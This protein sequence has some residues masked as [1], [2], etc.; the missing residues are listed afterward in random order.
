MSSLQPYNQPFS[1][2]SSS[3]FGFSASDLSIIQ[4]GQWLP[5]LSHFV[6]INSP[7][8]IDANLDQ[9]RDEGE[10]LDLLLITALNPH[11]PSLPGLGEFIQS[12]D[13]TI[14]AA[15]LRG[16][17]SIGEILRE[18]SL[19]LDPNYRH[20]LEHLRWLLTQNLDLTDD[21]NPS[22]QLFKRLCQEA[23][24]GSSDLTRWAAAYALQALDYPA[25]LRKWLLHKPP[26]EIE[27]E[28]LH[29]QKDQIS[30]LSESSNPSEKR[31]C[32][33]FWVYGPTEK[34]FSEYHGM[35]HQE[36]VHEVLSKLGMRGIR[37]A[38][39][40]G[41]STTVIEVIKLARKIFNQTSP[42][43]H[44]ARYQDR[45]TRQN[46]ANRLLPLLNTDNIQLRNLVAE[47]LNDA[48]NNYAVSNQLLNPDDRAKVA[49][50]DT[51]SSSRWD[52]VV[53]LGEITIPVLR[54]A[55]EGRLKFI[56]DEAQN[57]GFQIEAL[58]AIDRIIKDA[59]LKVKTLI[60]YL[61]HDSD[62]IRLEAFNFLHP[63]KSHLNSEYSQIIVA[64]NFQ[65][66][67][68][69]KL[70][71]LSAFQQ[72]LSFGLP[73][74]KLKME[75]FLL[76]AE[77]QKKALHQTF[78]K[79]LSACDNQTN[80]KD[81]LIKQ[82]EMFLEEISRYLSLLNRQQEDYNDNLKLQEHNRKLEAELQK[83]K[84]EIQEMEETIHRFQQKINQN[85]DEDKFLLS[86]SSEGELCQ[87]L[88]F[89]FLL[90]GI[91][92]ILIMQSGVFSLI[93]IAILVWAILDWSAKE[94][95]QEKR[96]QLK[97]Q[98]ANLN[99]QVNSLNERKYRIQQELSA[100][101]RQIK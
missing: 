53:S 2:Q 63:L 89:A 99:I 72:D 27:A 26:A 80:L 77:K 45:A 90:F 8:D 61:N 25:S 19:N 29:A 14:L 39:Q 38:L 86:S 3:I 78:D 54:D 13:L 74:S 33:K 22:V 94:S 84:R 6:P 42:S 51:T 35:Y 55:V 85:L 32:I 73:L 18:P 52:H 69:D 70:S 58:K 65:L 101:E 76:E 9:A 12:K 64:L 71:I 10:K 28:I 31:D 60:S 11:A 88:R 7:H 96:T 67:L 30:R 47:K 79:A 34:L 91:P 5:E 57:I 68:S 16:F 87:Q 66:S 49:V 37:L 48:D 20:H 56:E 41:N 44:D 4:S 75:A 93:W 81:F 1:W 23:E 82:Q 46:L 98:T 100:I 15:T 97:A 62:R 92:I 24:S 95:S 83:K 17:G 43:S 50:I 21:A 40:Y 36:V 59:P